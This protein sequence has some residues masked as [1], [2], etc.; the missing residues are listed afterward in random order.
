MFKALSFV[1]LPLF[2][3]LPSVCTSSLP[4]TSSSP[5]TRFF[6][7]GVTLYLFTVTTTVVA[8]ALV[9]RVPSVRKVLDIP[10]LPDTTPIKPPTFLDTV[11]FGVEWIKG[12][13]AEAEAQ[14][15]A[16]Q[17]KKF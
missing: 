13:R 12:K 11:Q 2:M 15:R 17:R 10:K 8:Q 7:Q 5:L 3:N 1:S 4:T 14:A 16:Q 9:L 6:R